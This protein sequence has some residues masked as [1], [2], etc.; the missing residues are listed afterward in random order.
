VVV[1]GETPELPMFVHRT[2]GVSPSELHSS[3]T[4][5]GHGKTSVGCMIRLVT[6]VEWSKAGVMQGDYGS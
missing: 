2:W 4:T 6:M 5:E 3:N 1:P